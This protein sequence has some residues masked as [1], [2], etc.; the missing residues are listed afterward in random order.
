MGVLLLLLEEPRDQA[1]SVDPLPAGRAGAQGEA[2]I[3]TGSRDIDP[4]A[5]LSKG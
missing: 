1:A 4:T 5:S 3:E 2:G